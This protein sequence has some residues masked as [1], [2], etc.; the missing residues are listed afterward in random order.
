[1][2]VKAINDL[3]GPDGIML[4]LLVFGAYLRIIKDSALLPFII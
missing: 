4:I 1:M 3:A 2:A